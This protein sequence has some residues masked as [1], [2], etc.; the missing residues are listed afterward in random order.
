MIPK[1][2]KDKIG[3]VLAIMDSRIINN[4]F[5]RIIQ[6]YHKRPGGGNSFINRILWRLIRLYYA[7]D[8]PKE[9]K[10]DGVYFCHH[11]FGIVIN[12]EAEIGQGTIIQHSVTIGAI[13]GKSPTIGC[14]C[15]IGARAI[16]IGG[17]IIG[18]NVKI[19]AGA[20][21]VKDIPDNCT[22]VGNPAKIIS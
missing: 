11:G 16:I 14:N 5:N 22:V 8:I 12:P 17:V 9:A 2:E 18:N 20:V 21:V 10:I 13:D 1:V 3:I 19:G 15:Y 4:R 7:C 6:W